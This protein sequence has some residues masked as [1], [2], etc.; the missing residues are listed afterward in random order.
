MQNHDD[1]GDLVHGNLTN[2]ILR[3]FFQVY[4]ELGSGFLEAVYRPALARALR[5][6]G[7]HPAIEWPIDV[8][9]RGE[10]IA[11][12]QAD[13]VVDNKV[14]LELKAVR[15]VLPEHHAQLIH[16]LRATTIEVGLLLNFGRNPEFKRFIYSNQNKRSLF[17]R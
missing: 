6:N 7:L 11:H 17:Q 2:R 4:N 5:D 13:V 10:V 15:N 1:S 9:F 16:Y 14:I 8:F 3:T 12:F